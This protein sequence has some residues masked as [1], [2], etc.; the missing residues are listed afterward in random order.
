MNF[1]LQ[2]LKNL[3]NRIE[4]FIFEYEKLNT[5]DITEINI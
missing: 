4:L 2:A 3:K 5:K 1:V